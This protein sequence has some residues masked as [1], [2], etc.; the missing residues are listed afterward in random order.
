MPDQ[1]HAGLSERAETLDRSWALGVRT[2][3]TSRSYLPGSCSWEHRESSAGGVSQPG[4]A[5]LA[6]DLGG[7]SS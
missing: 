1:G 3:G 7:A 2:A 4:A 6:A 5:R